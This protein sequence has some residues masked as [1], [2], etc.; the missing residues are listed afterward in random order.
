MSYTPPS[1]TA[2]DFTLPD[3]GYTPPTGSAIPFVWWLYGSVVAEVSLLGDAAGVIGAYGQGDGCLV[4]DGVGA[5]KAWPFGVGDYRFSCDVVSATGYV[6]TFG[7]ATAQVRLT[8]NATGT[9]AVVGVG[10]AT[11]L[12]ASAFGTGYPTVGEATV[13][14]PLFGSAVGGT[15]PFAGYIYGTGTGRCKLTGL[16]GGQ[17]SPFGVGGAKVFLTGSGYAKRGVAGVGVGAIALKGDGFAGRGSVLAGAASVNLKGSVSGSRGVAGAGGAA[18]SIFPSGRGNVP[19]MFFGIGNGLI[20][21]AGVGYGEYPLKHD[22]FDTLFVRSTP[23]RLFVV[24][25]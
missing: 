22:G 21:I 4:V 3:G 20:Q 6:A 15:P 23:V 14:I 7:S 25:Q 17:V 19:P 11:L 24:T 5:G 12:S 1:G 16:S 8:K 9:I 10:A 13:S 2:L 18:L